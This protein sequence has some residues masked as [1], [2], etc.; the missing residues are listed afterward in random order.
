M[1]NLNN[2]LLLS[3]CL[4]LFFFHSFS[5]TSLIRGKVVSQANGAPISNCSVFINNSSRGTITNSVGEFELRN[6]PA[7]NHELIVSSIGYETYVHSFTDKQFPIQLDVQLKLRAT[8]MESVTIE[9]YV[10]D[11]WK[12]WGDFFIENFI[13]NNENA[14]GCSIKN[15]KTIKFR[16]SKSK[17]RLTAS[18]DE[19]L[20]IVNKSLG[21]TISYQL[22]DFFSDFANSTIGYSGYPFFNEI[23]TSRAKLKER[24]KKNRKTAYQLSM[25]HFFRS[26]YLNDLDSQGFTV[27]TLKRFENVEKQRVKALYARPTNDTL[28][29]MNGDLVKMSKMEL[30]PQ[31]SI[32]YYQTILAKPDYYESPGPPIPADS[33]VS[34]ESDESRVFF[35]NGTIF[36]SYLRAR[37]GLSQQSSI[38][39]MT[40]TPVRIWSNGNYFPPGEVFTMGYWSKSEKLSNLLPIDYSSENVKK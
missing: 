38:R 5:Q 2:A 39:L 37:E 27:R 18:A 13:G 8:E 16:Y 29:M 36:I 10:K 32:H 15:T 19:P 6:I 34:G 12:Q 11:G 30:M 9:P 22:E 23:A 35:F 3:T 31:D 1:R 24:W 33:L 14:S 20:I 25:M 7:G 40:P 17:N 28:I 26:L 4:L 21:Y